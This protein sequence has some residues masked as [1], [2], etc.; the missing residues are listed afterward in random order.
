MTLFRLRLS[1]NKLLIFLLCIAL[2]L[3]IYWSR[4]YPVQPLRLAMGQPGSSYQ[5]LG[6]KLADY[7]KQYGLRIELMETGSM[8]EGVNKLDDN[9]SL[10]N[11]AFMTA[12]QPAPQQWSGL[13][14]LGSVQYSPLWL[15]YRGAPPKNDAEIFRKRIA[16]GADGT[17]TQALFRTLAQ[18]NG[19]KL[20]DQPNLIK[21]K[22][23]EA[24]SLLN[25]GMI[26]AVFMVDGFDSENVQNL[27]KHPDNRIYNFEMAD[28]YTRQISYLN[29]LSIPK[30]SLNLVGPN[31]E[32][33]KNILATSITLVVEE[34]THPYLQ[35][36]LLKAIR[37]IGN[38]G[39]RFFAPPNFFPA[40]LD[41]T[42]NLSGV[43][44]RFYESG[45]PEL[46]QHLP[47]WLAIYLDRFW[48]VLLTILAIVIPVRE[49]WS[50]IKDAL[51]R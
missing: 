40:Q 18:A 5:A 43:A 34:D 31:P 33:D 28:A 9:D 6:H 29:K 47:W 17:N 2:P 46:T 35:W 12:G 1:H 50:V 24:V 14:S 19:V 20:A 8:S 48:V 32:V 26:D 25:A 30:G 49:F 37:D 22:H 36:L 7:F 3:L 11:A 16:I 23:T 42:S 51:H 27:L 4:P 21:V 10:I 41:D 38:E 44:Q 15:I 45:F 39:S 13:V